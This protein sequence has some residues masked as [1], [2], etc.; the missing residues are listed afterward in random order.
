MKVDELPQEQQER[1]AAFRRRVARV[2]TVDE[3][4]TLAGRVAHARVTAK[5]RGHDSEADRLRYATEA[6]FVREEVDRRRKS[7]ERRAEAAAERE[8]DRWVARGGPEGAERRRREQEHLR[9]LSSGPLA[10]KVVRPLSWADR[11][12]EPGEV[13]RP[14][15]VARA[16]RFAKFR[17]FLE[18]GASATEEKVTAD[19]EVTVNA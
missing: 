9:D 5:L 11:R 4:V 1:L 8:H 16:R 7:A 17:Y 14:A 18:L 19:R 13:V 10:F 6:R 15:N 12:L 2:E 3:L